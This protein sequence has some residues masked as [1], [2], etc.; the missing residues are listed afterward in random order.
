M[1][2][3]NYSFRIDLNNLHKGRLFGLIER[4]K[5]MSVLVEFDRKFKKNIVKRLISLMN[6]D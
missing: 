4:P 1:L 5:C 6:I 3:I 2:L